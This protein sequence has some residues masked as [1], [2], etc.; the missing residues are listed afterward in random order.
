MNKEPIKV[1]LIENNYRDAHLISSLLKK[2]TSAHNNLSF[3]L[4]HANQL[5]TGITNLK[6]REFDVILLDL[7]LADSQ[8]TDTLINVQQT[9]G[10]TPI[11]VMTGLN[12]EDIALHMVQQGAQD[13]LV[14]GEVNAAMLARS[15][16]HAIER[17]RLWLQLE[18]KSRA[19]QASETGLERRN[20]DLDAF[21]HTMA[22]QIQNLLGH[23][24]G[25]ASYLEMHYGP[26]MDDE[27]RDVLYRILRSGNKMSNVVSELLLL[28]HVNKED[29]PLAP[30][31]MKRIVAEARKRMGFYAE[32]RQAQFTQPDDWP[33][34][35][36][37]PAWIEEA[38]VNYISNAL[39]YG[40]DPPVVELGWNQVDEKTIRF[41]VKDNGQGITEIEQQKLFIPHSR[42][43]KTNV[44]GEGLGLSIVR[45]IINKCQGEV[46]V[47]SVPSK[48]SAFWFTLPIRD[49][50]M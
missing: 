24:V 28:A 3:D 16:R 25:Y 30:L 8:G 20:R 22:H 5:K 18:E 31:N 37:Y 4:H 21:A 32:E 34:V 1:L 11:V 26:D 48:G 29:V 6:K 10:D 50:T 17:K 47:E 36:G 9:A 44:K 45:R 2:A 23:M 35:V 7:S 13:Y 33:D 41:W 43:L 14:K 39:K 27:G 15:L 46:G 49:E 40:G 12:D 38:W 42:L 19:L